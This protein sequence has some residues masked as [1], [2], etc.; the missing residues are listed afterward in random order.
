MAVQPLRRINEAEGEGCRTL[1]EE[2]AAFEKEEETMSC[3]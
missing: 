2:M 3:G 1:E